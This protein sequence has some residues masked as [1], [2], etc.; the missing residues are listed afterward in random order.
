MSQILLL[1]VLLHVN[2]L[3]IIHIY[4]RGRV[5]LLFHFTDEKTEARRCEITCQELQNWVS[6]RSK[7]W[8]QVAWLQSPC[9]QL[10][11]Y[12]AFQI[13]IIHVVP[14][15]EIRMS[16]KCIYQRQAFSHWGVYFISFWVLLFGSDLVST[17]S[18]LCLLD[19]LKLSVS[20]KCNDD[21]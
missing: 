3:Y 1:K 6:N 10:L 19:T 5:L 7:I 2:S 18:L 8:T 17:K 15:T 14:Y 4:L 21:E 11:D 20:T 13:K 9:S 16:L 12:N